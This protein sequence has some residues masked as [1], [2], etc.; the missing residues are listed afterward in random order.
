M[1]Q[2]L[3]LVGSGLKTSCSFLQLAK[4]DTDLTTYTFSSQ[5]FGAEHPCRYLVAA[6]SGRSNVARTL[7]S[8]TIGGVAATQI[9]NITVGTTGITSLWVAKVPTGA[10]GN[11]VAT[12]S[13]GMLRVACALYRLLTTHDATVAFDSQTDNVLSG[14]NLSVSL[15]VPGG[16]VAIATL[17]SNTGPPASAT[18]SG[19][20]EDFDSNSA[21]NTAQ[22]YSG[23]SAEYSTSPVTVTATISG[24][25][26][27]SVLAAAS[28]R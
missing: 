19:V 20:S 2:L 9:A 27:L 24:S 23:G 21:E 12:F 4:L 7:N 14:S 18:W 3:S 25:P 5:S 1:F 22:G 11:V 16:G 6:V 26:T 15:S 10:S 28:F 17:H 13:G 8:V